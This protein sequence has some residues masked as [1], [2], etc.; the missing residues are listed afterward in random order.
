MMDIVIKIA[1]SSIL[2]LLFTPTNVKIIVT[3]EYKIVCVFWYQC[4]LFE[5]LF[6][7]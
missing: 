5:G 2:K 6:S 1:P 4:H 7:D 3:M